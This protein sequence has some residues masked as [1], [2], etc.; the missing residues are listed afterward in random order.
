M[1]EKKNMFIKGNLRCEDNHSERQGEA[2]WWYMCVMF[3]VIYVLCM[4]VVY[5][6]L[7]KCVMQICAM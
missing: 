6:L 7:C 5:I 1:Q 3:I 4:C 2:G